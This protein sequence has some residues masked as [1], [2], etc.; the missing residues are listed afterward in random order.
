MSYTLRNGKLDPSPD[1]EIVGPPFNGR[2]SHDAGG[3][4][5]CPICSQR[6]GQLSVFQR[7]EH[8]E[9][10]FS[11]SQEH[12]S[13]SRRGGTLPKLSPINKVMNSSKKIFRSKG[14]EKEA[15]TN[16]DDVFW[17]PVLSS[18][19]PR[20]YTPA[21]HPVLHGVRHFATSTLSIFAEPGTGPGDVG[22]SLSLFPDVL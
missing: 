11:S 17:Y 5:D 4:L 15:S 16:A 14:K 1:I 12:S 2:L 19:P 21:M 20:N 13:P 8:V 9:K 10:H 22:Q 18:T 3:I 6:L 7:Q